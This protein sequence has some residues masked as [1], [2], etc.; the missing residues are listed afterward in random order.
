[1]SERSCSK[2]AWAIGNGFIGICIIVL[3]IQD[4]AAKGPEPWWRDGLASLGTCLGA[5]MV[6][7]SLK[8]LF[9]LEE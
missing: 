8:Y 9:W 6:Y 2:T 7:Y 1:M 3:S 4:L 5:L